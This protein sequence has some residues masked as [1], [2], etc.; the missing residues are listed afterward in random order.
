M[1]KS[2]NECNFKLAIPEVTLVGDACK[3]RLSVIGKLGQE[4]CQIAVLSC[5]LTSL[6]RQTYEVELQPDLIRLISNGRII[7]E[8]Q[9]D[10]PEPSFG[11]AGARLEVCLADLLKKE[12]YTVYFKRGADRKWVLEGLLKEENAEIDRRA[13]REKRRKM[14]RLL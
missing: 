6:K 7:C 1:L 8:G 3:V 13:L 10:K 5:R 12:K 11:L 2:Y 14:H 9:F 4:E